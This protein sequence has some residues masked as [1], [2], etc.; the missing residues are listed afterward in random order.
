M[1]FRFRGAATWRRRRALGGGCPSTPRRRRRHRGRFALFAQ[2]S[3]QVQDGGYSANTSDIIANLTLQSAGNDDGGFEYALDVRGANYSGGFTQRQV[4]IYNAYV[5]FRSAGGQLRPPGRPDVAQRPRG[6]G[7]GRRVRSSS[8]GRVKRRTAGRFRF[9]LFAGGEPDPFQAKL[10]N[11]VRKAGGY[12]ALDGDLGRRHVLGFVTIKNQG[13]TEREVV[14]LLNF[15]PVGRRFFMYQAAEYDLKGPGGTD[16]KGLNY[17]FV[18]ARWAPSDVVDFQATYHHGLSID[19]RTI[20]NDELNG[21]PVDSRLLTGF[22]FESVGGR[23]TVSV[24]RRTRVW[25]GYYRD[26]NNMDSTATG[27]DQRR[28]L[29]REHPRQRP[30]LH[31]LGQPLGPHGKPLRLLVRLPRGRASGGRSTCR[32]TT[33]PRSRCCR[34]RTPAGLRWSPRPESKRYSLSS[35]VNLNRTLSL[36]LTADHSLLDTGRDNRAMLGFVVRF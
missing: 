3:R 32:P 18:N 35:T 4:S 19:A 31:G 15:I 25:A 28:L 27:S 21:Q 14:T 11:G 17:V 6:A 29:G 12:V 7:V 34:S 23:V 2:S 5:G 16:K 36:L 1:T 20:T 9:G 10:V 8:I 26:R 24:S 22:L 30:R 33:Q 13:L